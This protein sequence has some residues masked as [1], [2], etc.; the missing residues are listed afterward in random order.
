MEALPNLR[1]IEEYSVNQIEASSPYGYVADT[2]HEVIPSV[3][4]D[5]IRQQ[6]MS[7]AK[8]SAICELRDHLGGVYG[9]D[10]SA[11]KLGWYVVVCDDPERLVYPEGVDGETNGIDEDGETSTI[12]NGDVPERK[13]ARRGSLSHGLRKVFGL[14][15]VRK[16]ARSVL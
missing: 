13:S 1:F 10:A 14:K 15:K 12:K 8:W 4:I 6:P 7:D 11:V 3:D 9:A 5:E 2:V 16:S